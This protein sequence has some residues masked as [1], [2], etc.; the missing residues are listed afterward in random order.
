MIRK[1]VEKYIKNAK[2]AFKNKNLN[3]A[4]GNWNKIYDTL[5]NLDCQQELFEAM[6]KFSNEEVFSITEH[7]KIISGYYS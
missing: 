4:V 6:S 7:Y 5:E 1:S 3:A 2:Q